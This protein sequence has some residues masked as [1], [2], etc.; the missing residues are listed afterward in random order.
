MFLLTSQLT[1]DGVLDYIRRGL[2]FKVRDN[3]TNRHNMAK[4]LSIASSLKNA[5]APSFKVAY[6]YIPL[7]PRVGLRFQPLASDLEPTGKSPSSIND[8][9]KLDGMN[10]IPNEHIHH[11]YQGLLVRTLIWTVVSDFMIGTPYLPLFC[12]SVGLS[13]RPMERAAKLSELRSNSP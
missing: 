9:K 3:I 6:Y 1:K 12:I 7:C 5:Y 8:M 11:F 10:I 2:L 13:N 4:V